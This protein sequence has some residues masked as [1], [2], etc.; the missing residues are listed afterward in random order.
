MR[1]GA[2]AAALASACVAR[3]GDCRIS[4]AAPSS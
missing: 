4:R 1:G 2:A 3:R